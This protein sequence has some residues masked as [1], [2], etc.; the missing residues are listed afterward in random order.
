MTLE[1]TDVFLF[2]AVDV[3]AHDGHHGNNNVASNL[4]HSRWSQGTPERFQNSIMIRDARQKA[5]AVYLHRQKMDLGHLLP[6]NINE[7]NF[8]GLGLQ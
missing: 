5:K 6:L 8:L 2:H 7:T 3:P 1:A 4:E